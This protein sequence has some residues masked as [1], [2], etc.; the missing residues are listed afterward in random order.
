MK[1]FE[2]EAEIRKM[3]EQRNA[4]RESLVNWGWLIRNRIDE[5]ESLITQL[6][7]E[8]LKLHAEWKGID[9]QVSA[10]NRKWQ[11]KIAEYRAEVEPTQ[12]KP[13]LQEMSAWALVKELE[14]RGYDVEQ[15]K[16]DLR[17]SQEI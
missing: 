16:A 8:V 3:R 10:I 4:E 6:R 2:M 17:Q 12:E 13:A 15:T 7:S 1:Q 9:L 14:R 5:K 11:E